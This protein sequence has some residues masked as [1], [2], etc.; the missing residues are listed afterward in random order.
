M[1]ALEPG[2]RPL[3]YTY[4]VLGTTLL[5]STRPDSSGR[6]FATRWAVVLLPVVP[7]GR[8]YVWRGRTTTSG[9]MFTSQSNTD[10][11]LVGR[12]RLRAPEILRVYLLC[13]LAVPVLFVGPILGAVLWNPDAGSDTAYMAGAMGTSLVLTSLL[14][15]GFLVYRARWRPI[16]QAR[17]DEPDQS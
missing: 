8:Y 2:H 13:W 14:L 7:L 16:R 17:W 1:W 11:T 15:V 5:Q 9:G 4:N 6:F 12:S 10:Y 3:L